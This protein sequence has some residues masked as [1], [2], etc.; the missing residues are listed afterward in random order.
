[1]KRFWS[2]VT[3]A[4]RAV[5]LDGRP[6]RTP[7]R[8]ELVLPSAA[9][10][11]AVAAEWR[12]VSGEIDPRAMP[13]TGLANAAIDRPPAPDALASYGESDVLCYRAEEPPE[14]AAR[15][16]AAWDPLLDWARVRFDVALTV[17]TGII[18]RDQPRETRARLAAAVGALDRWQRAG[19]NPLVTIGG[20][21]VTA[22]AVFEGAIDASA[23]FEAT[24]LD[25]LWQAE[26]W[27]EDW[28]ATDAR[29]ARRGDFEAAARFLALL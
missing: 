10:A 5:R 8:A 21:L 15:E 22:L 26:R 11:E 14:L 7:L 20:S 27:G 13:L 25:E 29:L 28:M 16:A 17:T 3:V 2:E 23:A 1:M 18:H 6:V 12:S 24:H 4:D 19:L 9:L